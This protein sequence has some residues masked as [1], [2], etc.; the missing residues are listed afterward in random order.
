[1]YAAL[2]RYADAEPLY[3]RSLAI[4][5]KALDPNGVAKSL[6]NLAALLVPRPAGRAGS[7]RLDGLPG[8]PK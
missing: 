8:R 2:G 4:Y 6:N 5:E 1:L 7:I 3:K